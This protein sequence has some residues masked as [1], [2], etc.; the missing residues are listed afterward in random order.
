MGKAVTKKRVELISLIK[1]GGI[2]PMHVDAEVWERLQRLAAS[3]QW[4]EKS[5]QGRYAN[6]C[7]KTI[8]R[9]GNRGVNGVREN[10]REILGRSP[11]PDEVYSEAHREKGSRVKKEKKDAVSTK[12]DS[13]A[14]ED[15]SEEDGEEES[16]ENSIQG[17]VNDEGVRH[18]SEVST[19]PVGD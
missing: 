18:R 15:T 2:Q 4:E 10:L 12:W 17:A 19:L 8:N 14:Q 6:A 3:K 16:R 1:R 7:R 13:S 5:Q 11:D 9:T